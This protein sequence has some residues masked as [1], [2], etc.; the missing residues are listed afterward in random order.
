MK[1]G[2][3]SFHHVLTFHGSASN[4]SERVRRSLAVHLVDAMV[5]SVSHVDGW[6]HY[7]LGL[8]QQRGGAVGDAYD[9]DDLWPV[10]FAR[11]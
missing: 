2:Q 6:Q 4:T 3:V 8:L 7:N 10:V 9:V 1:A 5:T 11:D